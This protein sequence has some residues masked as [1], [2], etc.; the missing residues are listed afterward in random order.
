MI[1]TSNSAQALLVQGPLKSCGTTFQVTSSS[2]R[3]K[4]ESEKKKELAVAP[5]L[6]R[7]CFLGQ[8]NYDRFNVPGPLKVD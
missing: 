8:R 6:L 4:K 1:R 2:A 3:E 5:S 7:P